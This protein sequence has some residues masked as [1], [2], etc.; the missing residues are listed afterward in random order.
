[1]LVHIRVIEAKDVPKMDLFG[2]ADPYCLLQISSSRTV[3]KTKVIKNTYNPIWNEEFHIPVADKNNDSLHILMKDQDAGKSDD[4]ISRLEI[5]ISTIEVDKVLDTWYD[6]VPVKGVKKG[7]KLRLVTHLAY[8]GATP[9]KPGT[10]PGNFTKSMSD[11]TTNNAGFLNA[12]LGPGP[13]QLSGEMN[14]NFAFTPYTGPDPHGEAMPTSP[15]NNNINQPTSP[16]QPPPSSAQAPP[17]Q[18]VTQPYQPP[19]GSA[20]PPPLQPGTQSYQP[21]PV[22]QQPIPQGYPQQ[23]VYQPPPGTQPAFHSQY[24]PQYQQPSQFHSQYQPQYQQPYQSQ[25]QPPYQQ[26][27]PSQFQPPPQRYPPGQGYPP[28]YQPK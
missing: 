18:P 2:K 22:P 19:P 25:F 16:Y 24:Q 11:M 4:P 15:P 10:A 1:M 26:Q 7:G 13:S 6:M 3:Y 17:L 23:P 27:Y 9:F 28:P 20:Q 21:P 5:R 8:P 12:I 14:P